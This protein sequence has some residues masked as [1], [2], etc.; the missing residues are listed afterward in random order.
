MTPF[1]LLQRLVDSVETG[2]LF[3]RT[4]E[5]HQARIGLADGRIIHIS[6]AM[7]RGSE[8][9]TRLANSRSSSASFTRGLASAPH[10]DLPAHDRLVRMLP[11]ILN[12]GV[13]TVPTMGTPGPARE[14]PT[15]TRASTTSIFGATELSR[16]VVLEPGQE[17]AVEKL[18]ALM[19]DHV[20]PIGGLLV[21]QEAQAGFRNWSQ[22]VDRLAR[23][24]SP[25]S[26]M[27]A[28]RIAALK[29]LP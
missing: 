2:I 18:R 17:A 29:L 4:A 10:E 12:E 24:V 7:R 3:V 14:R 26:A 16:S 28:F 15:G 27:Q 6:Y 1:E 13:A 21:D 23:E 20:G 19:V 9:L 25:Q 8:A 22:L 11:A 5:G